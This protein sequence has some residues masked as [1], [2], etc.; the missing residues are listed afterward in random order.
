[1]VI[2]KIGEGY[3]VTRD[4]SKVVILSTSVPGPY[5]VVGYTVSEEYPNEPM[6]HSWCLDGKFN[7][8]GEDN[9]L[10]LQ[11]APQEWYSEMLFTEQNGY[12]VGSA[13]LFKYASLSP[14]FI[15]HLARVTDSNG[16]VTHRFDP[17]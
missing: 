8:S 5:P 14:Y 7:T 15:G 4:S 17:K 6:L 2:D 3:Y 11:P 9:R 13:S 1:M 10:D 12:Q 16:N